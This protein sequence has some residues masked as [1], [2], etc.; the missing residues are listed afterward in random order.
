MTS[1]REH[2]GPNQAITT[3]VWYST[4][5]KA[6]ELAIR[7]TFA[8]RLRRRDRTVSLGGAANRVRHPTIGHVAA[9]RLIPGQDAPGREMEQHVARYAWAFRY[10]EGRRVLDVG[11]GAGYGSF[12]LSWVAQHVEGID[13]DPAAIAH[14]AASYPGGAEYSVVDGTTEA[15]HSAD[16]ATCFEVLEHV[17]E[18]EKLCRALMSAAPVVLLSYPNPLMA[19][20][21]LNPHH[22]VDWPLAVLRR[23]LSAAGAIG[24]ETFHQRLGSSAVRRGAPPWAAV[25]L[26]RVTR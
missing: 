24:C 17:T 20:P 12:L 18:P 14:A 19:G 6:E 5:L 8:R 4:L 7:A 26:L 15:L 1:M 16:V 2:N 22:R 23:A 9:E 21:H 11:C 3:P 13:R 25:W 10:V